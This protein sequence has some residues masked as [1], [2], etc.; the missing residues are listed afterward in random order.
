MCACMQG[1]KVS[2][3]TCLA[4]NQLRRVR[5][6]KTSRRHNLQKEQILFEEWNFKVTKISISH[7]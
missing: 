5:F 7:K 1:N 3:A 2:R 4:A 6:K